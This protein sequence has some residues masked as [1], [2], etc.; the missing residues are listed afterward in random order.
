MLTKE[1]VQLILTTEH[2]D[3]DE[4]LH[5]LNITHLEFHQAH[6]NHKIPQPIPLTEGLRLEVSDMSRHD[7]SRKYKMHTMDV[8]RLLY[9]EDFSKWIP[10]QEA[11]RMRQQ[12]HT[13]LHIG[14]QLGT[15]YYDKPRLAAELQAHRD[16]GRRVI[17]LA[18]EYSISHS[19][20]SQLTNASRSYNRL[21]REERREIQRSKASA[22]QLAKHYNVG[23]NTIYVIRRE[24]EH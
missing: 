23:L 9:H 6:A 15:K 11:K 2:M 1:L 21:T 14:Q 18:D 22:R 10:E 24:D 12:G 17:D 16:Q 8:D 5:S 19:R 13:E 3:L 20:V 7:I 4:T